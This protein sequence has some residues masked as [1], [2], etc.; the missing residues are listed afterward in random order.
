MNPRALI[1]CVLEVSPAWHR[2]CMCVSPALGTE[3]RLSMKSAWALQWDSSSKAHFL[4][5]FDILRRLSHMQTLHI[6]VRLCERC[7]TK[8][9]L[10][11]RKE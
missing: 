7:E 8:S 5:I 6:K 2:G 9:D 4:H 11:K 10:S 3:G 1:G